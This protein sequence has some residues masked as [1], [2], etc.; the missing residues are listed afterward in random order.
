MELEYAEAEGH[1]RQALNLEPRR[2][3]IREWYVAFLLMM[4]RREEALAEARRAVELDSL[5]PTANAELARALG[6][7]GRCEEALA[8]LGRFEAMDPPPLRNAGIAAR[9]YGRM[10]RWYEAV[11]ALRP[12]AG[13]D[14]G[15]TLA[16][17]GYM[18]ARAGNRAEALAIQARLLDRRR[19][20]QAEALALAFVPAALGDRDEAFDW[21]ERAREE[22]SLA[23]FPGLRVEWTEPPFDA[24][25]GD[26]RMDR[27][28]E[29]IGIQKR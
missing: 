19:R 22:G 18:T 14:S 23:F 9:C 7:N 16:L 5:S 26:R 29:R 10:G 6:A 25:Q 28:L 17:L 15:A 8:I 3:R 13:Q 24:L 12:Q 11:A 1:L 20:G 2:P 21:I 27:L 4:G